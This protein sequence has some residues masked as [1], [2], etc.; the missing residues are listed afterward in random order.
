MKAGTSSGHATTGGGGVPEP[1]HVAYA[2]DRN[3]YSQSETRRGAAWC[4]D[5][6]HF[7]VEGLSALEAGRELA[8]EWNSIYRDGREIRAYAL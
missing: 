8:D 4:A 2:S 7:I 5:P 3:P 1:G 6:E